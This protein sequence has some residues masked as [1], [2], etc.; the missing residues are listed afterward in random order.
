MPEIL[1]VPLLLF[2]A[3]SASFLAKAVKP[4]AVRRWGWGIDAGCGP[5][6]RLAYAVWASVFFSAGV[7]AGFAWN[8]VPRVLVIWL[9]ASVLAVF[10]AGFLD[11]RSHSKPDEPTGADAEQ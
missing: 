9:A 6:S 2:T 3:L 10:A 7:L 4:T 8:P 1:W 5:M 11:M